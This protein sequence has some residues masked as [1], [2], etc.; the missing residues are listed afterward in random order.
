MTRRRPVALRDEPRFATLPDLSDQ[1]S[2][3]AR[4]EYRA[5]GPWVVVMR[6]P[7]NP[8]SPR[9]RSV[10]DAERLRLWLKDPP[11][12]TEK[13]VIA[14]YLSAVNRA[15]VLEGIPKGEWNDLRTAFEGLARNVVR[16]AIA[17]NR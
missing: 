15:I 2:Y 12:D 3:A 6:T 7:R 16:N 4:P 8:K 10:G 14:L 5:L 11:S 9:T 17:S 1:G 13:K